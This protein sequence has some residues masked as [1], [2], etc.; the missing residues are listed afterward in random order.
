[1]D[2]HPV[3]ADGEADLGQRAQEQQLWRDW[4]RHRDAAA[5]ERLIALH[6]DFARIM[7]GKMFAG[8][9]TDEIEFNEYRQIASVALIEAVDRYDPELGA[10]FRT[11]ASQRIAGA[12]LSGLQA[13]S[14][15][16]RQLAL[17][18]RIEQERLQSLR[19]GGD[20]KPEDTFTRMASIAVG[21]ALG[22]VL[23][24]AGLVQPEGAEYPDN[25]YASIEH[26]Q[27]RQRLLK[28]VD[29]LPQRES[30]IV[31]RHYLQQVPFDE[32]AATLGVTKGRV[33]QLHRRALE[34]LRAKLQDGSG[35]VSLSL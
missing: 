12:I 35:S 28:L 3:N 19:E 27:L 7:A 34:L 18:H 33:A 23:D 29:E 24:D 30:T 5:R 13:L 15:R 4:R 32:I 26:R 20:A 16:A 17:K 6:I 10:S 14:E 8:R 11:Y 9:H 31:R 22:F 1:L 21:L 25:A 2:A